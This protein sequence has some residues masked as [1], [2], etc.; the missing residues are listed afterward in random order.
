M[1]L[2]VGNFGGFD[3]QDVLEQLPLGVL[4]ED[5]LPIGAVS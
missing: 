2:P 1:P 3:L 5:K 4:V